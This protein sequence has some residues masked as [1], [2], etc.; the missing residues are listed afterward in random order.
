M[1]DPRRIPEPPGDIRGLI[2]ESA[3]DLAGIIPE[4]AGDIL[5]TADL[6]PPPRQSGRAARPAGATVR[7]PFRFETPTMVQPCDSWHSHD[8]T[9]SALQTSFVRC[10][11]N[12]FGQ[13][14]QQLAS[15]RK[16]I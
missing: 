10:S 6:L 7:P 13:T 1:R 4:T 15:Q 9:G 11:P 3:G 8:G 16:N 2:P 5:R 12:F 14:H